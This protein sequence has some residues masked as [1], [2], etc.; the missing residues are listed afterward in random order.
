MDW[1]NTYV[2]G[3]GPKDAKIVLVGEAPGATEERDK[4]PFA[5]T[6]GKILDGILTEVGLHR[7][8]CYITNVVKYR[9]K[10]NDFTVF[11]DKKVRSQFLQEQIKF[12]IDEIN[13]I[14]P[15]IIV[16]LGNEALRA[17]TNLYGIGNWRGSVLQSHCGK[18]IGTYHPA[19]ILRFYSWRPIAVMD[20]KKIAEEKEYLDI[21]LTPR[22]LYTTEPHENMLNTL[23][24][25]IRTERKIAFDIETAADQVTCISFSWSPIHSMCVPFWFDDVDHFWLEEKELQLW[26]KVKELL[27]GPSPKIAQNAQFDMFWL[28][29]PPY[30][31]KVNNIWHDTMIAAHTLYPELPKGLDFLCSMYT[32]HPYYKHMIKTDNMQEYFKYNALDSCITYEVAMKQIEEMKDANLYDFFCTL[33]QQLIDPFLEM[34]MRGIKINLDLLSDKRKIYSDSIKSDQELLDTQVGHPLNTSSPKQMKEF[35]YTE[36]KLPTKYSSKKGKAKTVTTDTDAIKEL[37]RKYKLPVLDTILSIK[38]NRKI[39]STY[40]ELKLDSDKRVRTVYDITGTTTGRLASRTTARGTGM[41]LQNVPVTMRDMF[42]PD[43]GKV[44]VSA[45]LSQAEARVVAYIAQDTKLIEVFESGGD[46]HTRNASNIY[47]IPEDQVSKE[48]RQMAKKVVHASHYGMGPRKFA[49]IAGIPEAE[50]KQL[51]N[52]YFATYPKL[53]I[54]HLQTA[55]ELRRSRV[56]TT[57][58]GRRRLFLNSW[59]EELLREAYA[60]VP[61]STVSDILNTGL[62]SLYNYINNNRLDIQIMLQVHDSIT[63]QCP[64][65]LVEYTKKLFQQHLI[66]PLTI[67]GSTM[68]I[69]VDIQIGNTWYDCK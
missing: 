57:P 69:P 52:K 61:Q 9:P 37:K 64:I 53:K 58:M 2:A 47:G 5:G 65:K 55:Q 36:L 54:W 42:I 34:T 48:Q 46:I 25:L 50:S 41:N 8:E 26:D 43:D 17:L 6:A 14:K 32:D 7:D 10:N 59:N 28:A 66:L 21:T 60:F 22:V 51:L 27:E 15:N 18:L 45:D 62:L 24:W 3:E 39:Y 11:Y 35:L 56:L 67:Y 12:L 38:E 13:D 68:I 31:I 20:F 29:Q 63:V 19:A 4:R 23:D 44:F 1:H 40:L 16:A 49:Q 33:P 30:N